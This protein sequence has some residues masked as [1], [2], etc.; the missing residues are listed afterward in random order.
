MSNIQDQLQNVNVVSSDLLA[1]PEEVKRR[2]PLTSRAAQTVFKSRELVRAILE[3]RDPRLFIVVGPCSIHDVAAAREYASRL[4]ELAAEVEPTLTLI[5]RVYFEKPRTTVG[6]KGLINDPDLDDSFHIEK[7]IHLPR[8]LLLYVGERAVD[9]GGLQERHGRR[10]RDL[11]QRPAVGAAPSPL[12]RHHATGAVGGVSHARQCACA[13]GAARRRRTRQ[14]RCGEHCGRRTRIDRGRIARDGGGGLQPRQ[15]Q[16]G[17]RIAAPGGG[18]LHCANRRRQP[19][20][21]RAHA[22][23]SSE[24]GESVHSEGLEQARVRAVHHGSMHRLANHREP[25]A[26]AA[27]V[28]A[29]RAALR[30]ARERRS[31]HRRYP[32]SSVSPQAYSSGSRESFFYCH[33]K[34]QKPRKGSGK[35]R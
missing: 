12:S 19:L 17:S 7:G 18:E 35:N 25:A 24:G 33:P 22:R 9:A 20:H 26:Q 6:W 30:R 23:E 4:K 11:D 29:K 1:T 27:S 8:G 10:A 31:F 32:N 3:R 14:L 5:M 13:P 21:R 28:L 15:F 2:L 16:Q 34:N